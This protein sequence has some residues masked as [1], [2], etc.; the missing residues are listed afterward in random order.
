MTPAEIGLVFNQLVNQ[1]TIYSGKI[2]NRR[3]SRE[4]VEAADILEKSRGDHGDLDDFLETQGL[5]LH[6]IDPFAIGL[7]NGG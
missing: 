6:K 3:R 5:M 2:P 7:G 1:R 4:E